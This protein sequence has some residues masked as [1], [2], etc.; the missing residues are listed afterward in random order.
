M[1]LTISPPVWVL[2][3]WDATVRVRTCYIS[4]LPNSYAN[5]K[6]FPQG[7]REDYPD[8]P[9]DAGIAEL[10][11]ALNAAGCPTTFCCSGLDEDHEDGKDPSQSGRSLA[12]YIAFDVSVAAK[13]GALISE[14]LYLE[15]DNV[16]RSR[17]G[18]PNATLRAAWDTLL[19][20]I[21]QLS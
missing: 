13:L 9:V 12:G 1:P 19:I 20:D 10:I 4:G 2:K 21:L 18:T 15:G 16:I 6:R 3:P 8:A 14:P 11:V 7:G 17:F 5:P